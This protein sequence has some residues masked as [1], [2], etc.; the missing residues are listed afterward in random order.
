M[1]PEEN[2]LEVKLGKLEVKMDF[3]IDKLGELEK[4][5]VT[6][7]DRLEN[8]KFPSIDFVQFRNN[9]FVPL[10]NKVDKLWWNLALFLG[11][12]GTII[13]LIN[14]YLLYKY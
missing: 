10:K 6:R 7:V 3:V 14:W 9:E 1:T 12:G 4:G 8:G 2:N 5:L 11:G 13:T